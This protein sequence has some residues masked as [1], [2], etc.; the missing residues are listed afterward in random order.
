MRPSPRADR[1]PGTESDP[2]EGRETRKTR[3]FAL[4]LRPP[5]LPSESSP[6]PLNPKKMKERTL[7]KDNGGPAFPRARGFHPDPVPGDPALCEQEGMSLRDYFAATVSVPT[8]FDPSLIAALAGGLCPKDMAR[9]RDWTAD[10]HVEVV[11]WA[12]KGVAVYRYLLADAMLTARA[13][14]GG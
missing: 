3:L 14:G 1:R 4:S 13:K 10:D 9:H 8:E 2:R 12:A 6:G 11:S 5:R 7:N